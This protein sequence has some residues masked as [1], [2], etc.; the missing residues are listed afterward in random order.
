LQVGHVASPLVL[1]PLLFRP[2]HCERPRVES[3]PDY[4]LTV[5]EDL[6]LN[7][8]F[9]AIFEIATVRVMIPA[10]KFP[11][12]FE[13]ARLRC[14]ER[15]VQVRYVEGIVVSHDHDRVRFVVVVFIGSGEAV[16]RVW[17]RSRRRELR[18]QS[19]PACND[20]FR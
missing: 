20:Y 6:C 18:A 16:R 12:P 2:L 14:H 1:V 9:A 15:C 5:T 3:P 7:A 4:Q 13:C 11:Q 19:L 8:P 17:W 10:A